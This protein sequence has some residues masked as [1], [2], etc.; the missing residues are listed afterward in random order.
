MNT[1]RKR[2][3]VLFQLGGPDSVEAIEPFL[4]NL[5]SDPDIIDLP[6][7]FMFRRPLA[8]F[9]SRRRAPRV[10]ELYEAIGGHSPILHHTSLQ[11]RCLEEG[12]AAAGHRMP[13]Y[14]AMRYWHPMTDDAMRRI[15][16]DGIQDVVLLPLYPHYSKSTTGSSMNEWNRSVRRAGAGNLRVKLVESYHDHPRYIDAWVDRIRIALHRLPAAE[17]SRVHLVFSAH[18]T[19]IKL[20]RD[21]DPYSHHIRST[22]E[23]V[24]ARGSFGLPHHLCFQSKV[25]PQKWLEPSLVDTVKTLGASGVTHM[26]VVPIAFVSDHIETLSEINIEARALAEAAGIRRYEMTPALLCSDELM[27]CFTDLVLKTFER[28]SCDESPV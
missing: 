14:I 7:A 4:Y 28:M 2:G 13:V 1:A 5:F 27:S 23:R 22:Y 8:R 19:P 9:I 15:V 18:G 6:G 16:Q 25:G 10:K 26:I 20:V 12:L 11:A 3:V 24:I 17:R 21:G